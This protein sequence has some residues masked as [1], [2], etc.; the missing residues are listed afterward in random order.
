MSTFFVA[1]VA[2]LIAVS[3][4]VVIRVLRSGTIFSKLLAIGTIGTNT[5]ALMALVGFI[6]GQPDLFVDLALSYALLNF[7]GAVAAAKVLERRS[8][9]GS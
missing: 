8:R 5:V 7:I 4:L 6:F 2:T 1:A 3:L 9:E